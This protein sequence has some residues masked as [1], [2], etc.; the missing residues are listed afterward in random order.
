VGTAASAGR[1]FIHSG[2]CYP[3]WWSVIH[4]FELRVPDGWGRSDAEFMTG[5]LPGPCDQL[6]Q[7]QEG[8]ITRAQALSAGMSRHALQARLDSE[9][10][11]RLHSGVYATF[12]G[13]LGR[14]PV[15]WAAV[16]GAGPRAI[17]SHESAAEL[18]ELLSGTARQDRTVHVTVP[19]GRQ[20]AAMRHVRLHYSQRLDDSRHPVLLPPVTRVEDTILDLAVAAATVTDGIS[21]ILRACGTRRTTPDRLRQAM[22]ARRRLRWRNEL[23]A[24]LGD[25]R[26][27][28]HSALEYSYLHCVE[29]SHGLPAGVRQR[30]VIVRGVSTYQDVRYE[31]YRLIVELDGR[32]AHPGQERWRDIHR[33]NASAADGCI[34][35]RYSW[36]DVTQRACEVAAEVGRVLRSRGWTGQLRPCGPDCTVRG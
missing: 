10:W 3:Q 17:L 31:R 16:L 36:S 2:A 7:L 5:H 22:A 14:A 11:R 28:V 32:A 29:R 4:R 27:G 30:R 12:S 20:V 34:T 21:W 26:S 8:V 1:G 23:S 33:D 25:A 13:P 18:H 35:L 19:R 24:A 9:R 15:L 6:L